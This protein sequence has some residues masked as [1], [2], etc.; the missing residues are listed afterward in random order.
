M[1]N[2]DMM[3]TDTPPL[4]GRSGLRDDEDEEEDDDE[5]EDEGGVGE[6]DEEEDY[7]DQLEDGNGNAEEQ[8]RRIEFEKQMMGGKQF[9]STMMTPIQGGSSSLMN[10]QF[11]GDISGESPINKKESL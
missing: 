8:E 1:Q 7:D 5:D 3:M 4:E 9:N 11:A 2:K 10:S 6:D